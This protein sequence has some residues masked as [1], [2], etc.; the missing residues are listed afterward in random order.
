M[1]IFVEPSPELPLVSFSV[2]FIG[3]RLHEPVGKDGLAR[4]T[5]RMLRRGA[6]PF[7]AEQLEQHADALG[8][9]LGS[10][11]GLGSTTISCE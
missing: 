2:T 11:V 6:G 7:D 3:G 4:V 10:G 9:E 1:R 5:A 8:A